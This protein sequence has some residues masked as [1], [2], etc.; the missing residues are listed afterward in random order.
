MKVTMDDSGIKNLLK[1][2]TNEKISVKVGILDNS[3][4]RPDGV[5]N[6]QIGLVHEFGSIKKNINEN[7]FIRM[8]LNEV[9][10]RRLEKYDLVKE[11]SIRKEIAELGSTKKLAEKM[12]ALAVSVIMEAFATQGFG[13]WKNNRPIDNRTGMPL[14]DTQRLMK[15]ITFKVNI[16]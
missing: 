14:R 5:S 13:Q 1:A 7:S 2:L 10:T 16:K 3:D 4:K 9:F 15:S 11:S 6:A 12:G 8:P